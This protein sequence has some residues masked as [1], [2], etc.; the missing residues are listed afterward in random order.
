MIEHAFVRLLGGAFVLAATG[1]AAMS[2]V[3]DPKVLW[4]AMLWTGGGLCFLAAVSVT[5]ASTL[6]SG[7]M[8]D[9][10]CGSLFIIGIST[11][12]AALAINNPQPRPTGLTS[13]FQ[14]SRQQE[15]IED[16]HSSYELQIRQTAAQEERNR[17]ARDLHDSIKQQIFAIQTSAATAQVRFESDPEGAKSAIEAVRGSAR[18]ATAEME[19]MLDQLRAA[20][21]ELGGLVE[22]LRKHCEA[23]GYRTGAEVK[24]ELGTI[25][26]NEQVP[27]GFAQACFRIAQESLANVAKHARAG[28][29][30]VSL[31]SEGN[32]L[33]LEVKDNGAGFNTASVNS[34][35]GLENIK[36]RVREFK[37]T[38]EIV[39][40][41][42]EGTTM[43][44]KLPFNPPEDERPAN[45]WFTFLTTVASTFLV[46]GRRSSLYGV[47]IAAYLGVVL[48][49]LYRSYQK[50]KRLAA[51]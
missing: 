11:L 45:R 20:P 35:M 25:P 51:R 13:L 10:I 1:I 9:Y 24:F 4:L 29:V 49:L 6:W 5:Q 26:K 31:A 17:L 44:A 39:S 42:G 27:P 18:E 46:Q 12:T 47:F 43:R 36:A 41:A 38:V 37:G 15:S 40:R 30:E 14:N 7:G 33:V 19:V 21:L 48:Y 28:L 2:S 8:G 32:E 3:R 50:R 16:L 22:S 34:G 23:L